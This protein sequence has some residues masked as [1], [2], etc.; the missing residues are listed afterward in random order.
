MHKKVGSKRFPLQS[1]IPFKHLHRAFHLTLAWY[2]QRC[3]WMCYGL[4]AHL[5]IPVVQALLVTVME[6]PHRFVTTGCP[7]N[8]RSGAPAL[9]RGLGHGE[10]DQR[11]SSKSAAPLPEPSPLP[12]TSPQQRL[13]SLLTETVRPEE[14]EVHWNFDSQRADTAWASR[15]SSRRQRLQW[16]WAS[17]QRELV[18][19]AD[20]QPPKLRCL[21]TSSPSASRQP[22]SVSSMLSS[23]PCHPKPAET[24]EATWLWKLQT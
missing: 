2:R 19:Q 23:T 20:I 18:Q 10:Q 15:P 12:A 9:S 3:S 17:V 21:L 5:G 24:V 1:D 8:P 16:S 6:E 14:G 7:P 22:S 11:P 4:I 13:P